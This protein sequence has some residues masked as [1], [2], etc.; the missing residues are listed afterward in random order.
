MKEKLSDVHP[1]VPKI[2][3]ISLVRVGVSNVLFPL[4]VKKKTKGY[5][6]VMA[7]L[8]MFGSLRHNVKGLD[9]SRLP[10]CLSGWVNRPLSSLNFKELLV[11]LLKELNRGK[12]VPVSTDV[13]VRAKFNYKIPCSSPVTK[14]K[15]YVYY[16]CSFIGLL[17]NK[18]YKFIIGVNV[19]VMSMCP[20]S[21]QL[22][23]VDKEKDIGKGAH[24]QK[25]V[26]QVQVE[27]EVGKNVWIEDIILIVEK[28]GSSKVYPIL[29]RI[30]EKY[31]TEYSYSNPKFVEDIIRET[32][33]GLRNSEL[34]RWIRAKVESFESIH[35][36]TAVAY[37]EYTRKGKIW[38]RTNRGFY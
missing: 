30:D 9:M 31:V 34:V 13:F 5:Q 4:R 16:E 10:S 24:N 7:T 22:C 14:I 28:S 3:G 36:H 11:K 32:I 17:K 37:S 21:K 23:L 8:D 12:K 1:L 29:K 26:I 19:P 6:E 38:D 25:C 35:P 20:C 33:F 2:K 27:P 18:V 15:S